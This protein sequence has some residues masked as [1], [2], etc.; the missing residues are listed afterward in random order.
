[1]NSSSLLCTPFACTSA[2]KPTTSWKQK[3]YKYPLHILLSIYQVPGTAP[4]PI[5]QWWE[6]NSSLPSWECR[7]RRQQVY[8]YPAEGGQWLGKTNHKTRQRGQ[9]IS[10]GW[11]W[12]LGCGGVD[13][14]ERPED[15]L[16]SEQRPWA[17]W[18]E[19]A[20]GRGRV[21]VYRKWAWSTWAT[22]RRLGVSEQ[23]RGCWAGGQE[24]WSGEG[25]M[26]PGKTDSAV[27][28]RRGFSYMAWPLFHPL[29]P[30]AAGTRVREGEMKAA[31]RR[32]E[33]GGQDC[34]LVVWSQ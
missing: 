4:A 24:I 32:W 18:A 1:M 8:L 30:V 26:G 5:G 6:I 14:Q 2:R 13:S 33:G 9:G 10:I 20:S 21:K 23:E 17:A 16:T 34:T 19:G 31:E 25:E 15:K 7:E 11:G 29:P 27:S 3:A 28:W 22:A 12:G